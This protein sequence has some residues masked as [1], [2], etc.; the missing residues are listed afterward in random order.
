MRYDM[1]IPFA[2]RIALLNGDLIVVGAQNIYTLRYA[3]S[4]QFSNVLHPQIQLRPYQ[5]NVHFTFDIFL[6]ASK[7]LAFD[8]HQSVTRV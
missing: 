1:L 3:V 5:T 7:N 6:S 2:G 4:L 8:I